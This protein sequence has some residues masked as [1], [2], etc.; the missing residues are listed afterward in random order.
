MPVMSVTNSMYDLIVIGAGPV[1]SYAAYRSACAGLRVLLLEE[2]AVV[3]E[4]RHCTGVLGHEAYDR[5][6]DLPREP[7]QAELSAA[8]IIAPSG[9]RI[10]TEWFQEQA[11][12]VNRAQF[13]RA[14]ST[15]AVAAGA[16][17]RTETCVQSIHV[18]EGGVRLMVQTQGVSETVQAQTV[19]V[20]TGVA[21]RL[22]GQ[23]GLVPPQK[24]LV[25]AQ[26]EV[27]SDYI[28]EVEVYMGR[29]V[30]PGS[31][32]WAVPLGTGRVRLGVTAHRNAAQYLEALTE[33][34]LLKHRIRRQEEVPVKRP[35]P[36]RPIACS[37][38]D[39]VLLVGD[40]AGQVK[41]TTAGGI[42]YG[43][44]G[45]DL[46]S[47]T[48]H[49]AFAAGDFS[50]ARLMDY[51]RRWKSAL[52]ME[53]WLGRLSRCIFESLSDEK[54][55]RLVHACAHKS[56]AEMIRREAR[57][58]WHARNVLAFLATPHVLRQLF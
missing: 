12:V 32:A 49:K 5:F 41:P 50:R 18:E 22:H 27:E 19:I 30:A 2:H 42:Y 1:G 31:F 47:R 51:D 21:Y 15:M 16:A 10:R 56:I 40:A 53:M 14:L 7:I 55:D 13:D 6:P 45:A 33:S 35:V 54:L 11:V 3:G 23:L 9:E 57:F 36:I 26:F 58:D 8:W 24:H 25:C 37:V 52:R 39:R 38:T 46:A 29:H 4:P 17:L 28:R 20:A 48:L 44:I 43:L 34:P